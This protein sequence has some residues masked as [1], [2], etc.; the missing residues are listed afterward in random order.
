MHADE[1]P[2]DLEKGNRRDRLN[3][4]WRSKTPQE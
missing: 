2:F 4:G 1:R 3:T